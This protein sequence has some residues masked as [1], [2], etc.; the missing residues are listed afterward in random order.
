MNKWEMTNWCKELWHL[1]FRIHTVIY[2]LHI[3]F[4][5]LWNTPTSVLYVCSSTQLFLASK[6][7]HVFSLHIITRKSSFTY[8]RLKFTM[9][10]KKLDRVSSALRV[11]QRQRKHNSRRQPKNLCVSKAP[12]LKKVG[13][14][15]SVYCKCNCVI[16]I[17]ESTHC[18]E[19]IP[20]IGNKY[21]HDPSAYSAAGKYVDRSW[22]YINCSQT[23]E[24][25]NWDWGG[26]VPRKGIH[27]WDFR[28]NA[29]TLTRVSPVFIVKYSLGIDDWRVFFGGCN[30]NLRWY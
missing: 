5:M 24:C 20:K 16:F 14:C 27:K 2:I 28:N 25:G 7:F 15:V 6:I 29:Y 23:H 30:T 3:P 4:K 11:G 18:Q 12:C 21:S 8:R 13:Y 9:S 26:A 19:T 1:P 22:E 10:I 17:Y